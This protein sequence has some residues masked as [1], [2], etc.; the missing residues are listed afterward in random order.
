MIRRFLV[1]NSW[2]DIEKSD[3]INVMELQSINSDNVHLLSP[4]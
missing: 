1:F 2:S 3:V 4:Y